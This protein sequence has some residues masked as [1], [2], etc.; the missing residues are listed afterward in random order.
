VFLGEADG[1]VHL[2]RDRH[3]DAG[4]LA[5][6]HLGR[7]DRD[8]IET[9]ERRAG[10]IGRAAGRRGLPGQHGQ[11]LLDRLLLADRLAELHALV[12]IAD[13]DLHDACQRTRHLR[14]T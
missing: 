10:D 9:V 6:A 14:H 5:S 3:G 4:G 1:A 7:R 13:G 8:D 11:L 12:G 2:M